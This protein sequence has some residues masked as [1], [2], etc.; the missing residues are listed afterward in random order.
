MVKGIDRSELLRLIGADSVQLV[1]VL[2][3]AEYQGEHIP[4]AVNIP[5][6]SL[7]QETTQVLDRAKP[8]AVY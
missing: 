8:V 4:G 3:A 6:K 1:D 2:P 5:L 7:N